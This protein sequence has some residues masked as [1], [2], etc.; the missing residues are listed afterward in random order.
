MP[1][2]DELFPDN[3]LPIAPVV[4]D[5]KHAHSALILAGCVAACMFMGSIAV[6]ALR[7]GFM[8]MVALFILILSGL[9]IC[10]LRG[11]AK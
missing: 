10:V 4:A 1:H 8:S 3:H 11:A 2:R 7:G 9:T 5:E 6:L